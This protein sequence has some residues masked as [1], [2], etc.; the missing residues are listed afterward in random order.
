MQGPRE[1]LLRFQPQARHGGANLVQLARALSRPPRAKGRGRLGSRSPLPRTEPRGA[2]CGPQLAAVCGPGGTEPSPERPAQPPRRTDASR[3]PLPSPAGA[4]PGRPRNLPPGAGAVRRAGRRRGA[5][6]PRDPSRGPAAP[7]QPVAALLLREPCAPDGPAGPLPRRRP[8]PLLGH[9]AGSGPSGS[10][11]PCPGPFHLV[12]SLL[13]SALIP[14]SDRTRLVP[15]GPGQI[16][17]APRRVGYCTA[18][19]LA[20]EL[21]RRPPHPHPP[22][23]PSFPSIP[24][25]RSAVP[26]SRHEH[27]NPNELDVKARPVS[28]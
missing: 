15:S 6:A 23:P 13:F 28:P 7:V 10:S 8:S 24:P 12:P 26:P 25:P 1:C 16:S 21:A 20:F 22:G 4:R 17:G 14:P 18:A 5:R 2:R 19:A 11:S 3:K 27:R 9:W